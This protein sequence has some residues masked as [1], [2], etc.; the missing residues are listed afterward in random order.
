MGIPIGKLSLYA[1][2]AGLHP[3]R[4]LPILLDTGTDNRERLADP[5]YI[6]WRHERVRGADYA[7]FMEQFVTAVERRWPHVLL[8]WGDF[9]RPNAG[10]ILER[11][12]DRLCAF[13]DDIQGTA[14]VAAGTL[15][16][17]T[18]VIGTAPVLRCR[19]PRKSC[20]RWRA[21]S[22]GR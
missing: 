2:C 21:R 19:S 11:Y 10:R 8:Q 17:A 22:R 9:A 6:G 4:T 18:H 3:A 14:A 16:A 7:N 1:A 5:I 15:L 20:A 12:R 13:N